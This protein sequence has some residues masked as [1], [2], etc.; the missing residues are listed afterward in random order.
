V[1]VLSYGIVWLFVRFERA[2]GERRRDR[3]RRSFSPNILLG[4]EGYSPTPL[5]C[6]FGEQ[7]SA[8]GIYPDASVSLF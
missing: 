5:S 3:S 2:V 7:Q 4:S 8:L 1:E 6:G